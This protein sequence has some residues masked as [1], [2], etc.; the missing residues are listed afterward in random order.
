MDHTGFDNLVKEITL[1]ECSVAD[2]YLLLFSDP[3]AFP[4]Q[5]MHLQMESFSKISQKAT[6]QRLFP[7]VLLTILLC[8]L[9]FGFFLVI[10]NLCNLAG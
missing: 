9:S 6:L 3:P 7:A 5:G 4:V 8:E 10:R 2:A 1:L